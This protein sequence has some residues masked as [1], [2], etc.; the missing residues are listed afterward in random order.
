MA[1]KIFT[2]YGKTKEELQKMSTEEFIA[3][4]PTTQRRKFKRGISEEHK[5]LIKKI[6]THKGDK[7][8]RTQQR[9]AI[10]LPSF[11]N[12]KMA[13]YNGKDWSVIE[14]VPEMLGHYLGEYAH[15]R[16][17]VKHSGPGIGATRGTKF[18]SVK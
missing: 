13:V 12:K 16:K 17:L 15:T 14:I 4:M 6:E 1:K 2:L 8:I 18:A 7:L 3:L 9:D 11:I 5:K 10:I